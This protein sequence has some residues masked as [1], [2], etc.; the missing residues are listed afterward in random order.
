MVLE[1][2]I[3]DAFVD[4]RWVVIWVGHM[5]AS[6]NFFFLTYIVVTDVF[7]FVIIHWGLHLEFMNF[8][9]Y[10]LQF[11]NNLF[12]KNNSSLLGQH[13]AIKVPL[14]HSVTLI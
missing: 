8:S 7:F 13:K 1:V 12:K 5:R 4:E 14:D 3:G 6:G 10:L 2:S 11:N 9:L